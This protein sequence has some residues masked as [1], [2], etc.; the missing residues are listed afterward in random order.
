MNSLSFVQQTG[1]LSLLV[2][3]LTGIVSAHGLFIKLNTKDKILTRILQLETGV[4]LVEFVFYIWMTTTFAFNNKSVENLASIRYI[5][6]VI[7]TPMMLLSTIAFMEYQNAKKK[8]ETITFSNFFH[9]NYKTIKKMFLYNFFMLLF[10][11]L[12]EQNIIPKHISI[13]IGFYFFIKTF[14]IIKCFGKTTQGETLF[15]FMFVIWGLYGVAA[16]MPTLYKNIAY[17]G[18]DVIA[19]NFYGLFIYYIIIKTS[20]A[21]S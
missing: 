10:G 5:D 6:W 13:F 12:G 3:A 8:D 19:K 4:Q 7:T 2:Q 9:E 14:E 20:S 11:F 18:L 21:K 16:L 17:N 1:Q 15:Q